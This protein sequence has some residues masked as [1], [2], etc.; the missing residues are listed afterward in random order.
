MQCSRYKHNKENDEKENKSREIKIQNISCTLYQNHDPRIRSLYVTYAEGIGICDFFTTAELTKDII[1]LTEFDHTVK[2]ISLGK[3]T[4]NASKIA[5][6]FTKKYGPYRTVYRDYFEDNVDNDIES[7]YFFWKYGLDIDG[8]NR[9]SISGHNPVPDI[10]LDQYKGFV[11]RGSI[12]ITFDTTL[13]RD[14][15]L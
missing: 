6:Q 3:P 1:E 10:D 2:T 4:T 13:K 7:I 11:D 8:V 12:Y 14:C 9:I 5:S 15:K